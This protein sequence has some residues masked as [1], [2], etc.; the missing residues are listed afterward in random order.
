MLRVNVGSFWCD[1]PN[2]VSIA[3][4]MPKGI[5]GI[6]GKVDLLVPEW[7][8]VQ[9][10][11]QS[12][13]DAEAWDRYEYCYENNLRATLFF[14]RGQGHLSKAASDVPELIQ[15]AVQRLA[16]SLGVE[17]ITLCCWEKAENPYCHRKLIYEWMPE[18]I[19][20]ICA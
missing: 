13:Q 20:G 10:F 6:L 16:D 18:A 15:D 14:E 7:E 8:T 1:L 12:Q 17:E 4:S 3:I 19:R 2:K 9:E 11:K 5:S